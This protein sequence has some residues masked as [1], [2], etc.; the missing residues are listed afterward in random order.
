MV[1]YSCHTELE[2]QNDLA[3]VGRGSIEEISFGTHAA[4][5]EPGT[6]MGDRAPTRAVQ[7]RKKRAGRPDA[8]ARR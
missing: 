7:G 2:R 5:A 1:V 3:S 8:I 6:K 4:G